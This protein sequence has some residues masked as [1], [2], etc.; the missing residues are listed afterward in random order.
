MLKKM[1]CLILILGLSWNHVLSQN[2]LEKIKRPVQL[3]DIFAWKQLTDIKISPV[4]ENGQRLIAFVVREVSSEQNRWVPQIWL[5]STIPGSKPWQLTRRPRGA[6][7]P[8]WSPD[9]QGLAFL[10]QHGEKEKAKTQIFL[11]SKNGGEAEPITDHPE[12]VDS[13]EW[14]HDGRAIYFLAKDPL[15]EAEKKQRKKKYDAREVEKKFQYAHLYTIDLKTRTTRRI[16]KGEYHIFEFELSPDGQTLAFAAAPTPLLNYTEQSEIYTVSVQGGPRKQITSSPGMESNLKWSPDGRWLTFAKDA[17][18][19]GT[20]HYVAPSRLFAVSVS[21]G[22]PIILTGRIKTGLSFFGDYFWSPDGKYIDLLINAGVRN[23]AIRLPI[24]ISGEQIQA[25]KPKILFEPEGLLSLWDRDLRGKE[26]AFA[27]Q[28]PEQPPDV[29]FAQ[30][31]KFTRARKITDLNPQVRHLKLAR[32]EV[33]HWQSKDGQ[34]VEGILYYP[35]DYKPNNPVPL[36]VDIHGGPFSADR[37]VFEM[38]YGSPVHLYSALGYATLMVNYRGSSGYGEEF[39]RAIVGHYYEYDVMDIL[40]GVDYLIKKGIADPEHLGLKGWSNGGILTA[41]ITTETNRFKAAVPGAG[42]V[43]WISDFGNADIGIPFDIE[44]FGGRP[45]ENLQHYLEKSPLFRMQRVTTPTLIFFGENDVR[46]PVEQGFQHFRTLK[47]LGKMVEFVLFPRE[48]H[49]LREVTHQRTKI[50]K[51]TAWFDRYVL[52]VKERPAPLAG[53]LIDHLPQRYGYYGEWVHGVLI[54]ETITVNADSFIVPFSKST[55]GR[56]AD[57]L[58]IKSFQMGRFE[59]T[60]A[61][62][63][64]FLQ[65]NP[66]IPVPTTNRPY[67]SQQIWDTKNRTFQPGYGNHPVVGVTPEEAQQYCQWLSQKT[68]RKYRLPTPEEWAYVAVAGKYHR[69]PWGTQFVA[70]RANSASTWAG[71]TVFDAKAFFNSPKGHQKLTRR[72]LTKQVGE[73]PANAWGFYDL[74]GN[75]WEI[76]AR[77]THF[78]AKGGGWSSSASE[79]QTDYQVELSKNTRRNDMGFRVVRF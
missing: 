21:G 4:E 48:G 15:S 23:R 33:L 60:N 77:G 53:P 3:E 27:L 59:V 73:F 9:G 20:Y 32:H 18:Q 2:I 39:G 54:P 65:K 74:S 63:L 66:D 25:G 69:F 49:G 1:L 43:N 10:S 79:L 52:E 40:S 28:N 45:W 75:A 61:Q 50:E 34:E 67:P 76:T 64:M 35:L 6:Y 16:T 42:D 58:F 30:N 8:R 56:T 68:G 13:F 11:V 70:N 19:D 71:Y 41:W 38:N 7:A 22:K 44:Y 55:D 29:Y 12:G 17:T 5:I 24:K 31:G 26:V 46:V 14:S 62:Y 47:E 57:T 72:A 36:I 37:L 78:V 51:E